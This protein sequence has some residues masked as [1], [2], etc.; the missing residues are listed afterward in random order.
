MTEN[1]FVFGKT[2]HES[3][4]CNRSRDIEFLHNQFNSNAN[5]ILIS[6]RRWGKSSLVEEAARRYTKDNVRFVFID[7]FK[8]R[9]P[10]EFYNA[11]VQSLLK[12]TNSK[13]EEAFQFVS[14]W[15]KSIVPHLSFQ[16]DVNNEFSIRFQS[17]AGINEEDLLNLPQTL[18]SKKNIRIVLCIDEFQNIDYFPHPVEFQR[19]LRA[20]WQQHQKVHYCLYGSKRHLMHQLFETSELP[21]YRFGAVH[22]LKKI[23]IG[24]WIPFVSEKFKKTGKHISDEQTRVICQAMDAHS[25]YTQYAFQILWYISSTKVSSDNVEEALIRLGEQNELQ[26][27]KIVE[28]LTT[29]QLNYLKALCSETQNIH[30]KENIATFSLGTSATIQRSIQALLQKDVIDTMGSE[31]VFVDPAFQ[32]WFKK[33]FLMR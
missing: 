9:T 33:V 7:L 14:K 12:A 1:P 4:F 23:D 24:E 19:K 15:V 30:S 18:A 11:Y 16:P 2:V 31:T 29:Y 6:P 13:T 20:F 22:Y 26:F 25:Y 8:C 28:D 5:T 10:E 32:W 17:V 27:Y 3:D 21:F